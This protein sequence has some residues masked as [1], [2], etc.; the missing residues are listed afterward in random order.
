[1]EL[2]L[3]NKS[4]AILLKQLGFDWDCYF[5]YQPHTDTAFYNEYDKLNV[6]KAY[7]DS[8]LYSAPSAPLAIKWL[9]EIKDINVTAHKEA[10]SFK[11]WWTTVFHLTNGWETDAQHLN[12]AEEAES[13]GIDKALDYLI[14]K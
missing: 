9:R 3:V 10:A 14:K 1:M 8:E 4:Q 11:K 7:H 2:K 13:A 6:N 12:S 5:H